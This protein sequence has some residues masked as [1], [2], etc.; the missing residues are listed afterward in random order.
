MT[1]VV[2]KE[3]EKQYGI[4]AGEVY[5]AHRYQYDP[6]KW[7]LDARIPDGYCPNCSCYSSQVDLYTV[8][9]G[10]R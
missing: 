1:K 7:V 8:E 4:K 9:E 5:E 10:N 3:T 6:D 2:I